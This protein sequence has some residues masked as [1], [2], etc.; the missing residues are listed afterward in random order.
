MR[1]K[2]LAIVLLFGGLVF[3]LGNFGS[4]A[5]AKNCSIGDLS[6]CAEA[7]LIIP[8]GVVCNSAGECVTWFV[9][10]VFILATLAS[11]LYLVYGGIL[12]ITAGGDEGKVTAARST[13]TNAVIGL[14][15]VIV[16]WAISNFILNFFGASGRGLPGTNE[17]GIEREK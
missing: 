11:F 7:N 13:I 2:L 4:P 9:N 15:I 1:K 3:T 14:I 17:S 6:G 8:T 12:Y 16:S 10:V 5:L